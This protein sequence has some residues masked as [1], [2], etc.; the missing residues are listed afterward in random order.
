V[1][2]DGIVV[3]GASLAGVTLARALRE[4]GYD[5]RLTLVGEEPRPPYTRPPL[6]KQVL[7]GESGFDSLALPELGS[8]V[9]V[10]LGARA[11][12]LDLERRRVVLDGGEEI[13]FDRLAITTGAGARRLLPDGGAQPDPAETVVRS[14]DDALA[15]RERMLAKPRMLIVGG[16]FIGIEIASAGRQLGCEVTIVDCRPPLRASL[17]PFLADLFVTAARA[18]GVRIVVRPEPGT[19]LREEGGRVAGISLADGTVLEGDLVVSAVG[20]AANVDWLEP[21]GL[22]GPAGVPVDDRCRVAPGIVAAGDVA[23]HRGAGGR[24]R[25]TPHWLNAIDQAKAAART[26]VHGDAAPT[27]S[28]SP[29]FW[30]EGFGIAA[31]VAGPLP[32]AGEPSLRDGSDPSSRIFEWASRGPGRRTVAAVNRRV[33][34]GKLRRLAG[35]TPAG[36]ET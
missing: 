16:G 2:G 25:R 4:E 34:V 20:C 10:L 5:G 23:L 28:Y 31:R 9:E 18:A 29:Y 14:Y 33:S 1:K 36:A 30:T 15:L 17:G 12:G 35:A 8:D 21:T 3:V 11:R 7:C 26:L 13:G 19:P 32:V 27:Y 22:A 24:P 6:T